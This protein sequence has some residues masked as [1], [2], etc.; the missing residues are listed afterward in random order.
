M[1]HAAIGDEVYNEFR[2]RF[3]GMF[4]DPRERGWSAYSASSPVTGSRHS[5]PL[6]IS[7][8]HPHPP[9]WSVMREGEPAATRGRWWR[10]LGVGIF[11]C[12]LPARVVDAGRT[13]ARSRW[14]RH[15]SRLPVGGGGTARWSRS[16]GAAPRNGGA[17]EGPPAAPPEADPSLRESCC[18][19]Q[20]EAA[21][22]NFSSLDSTS[23][24]SA[25]ALRFLSPSHCARA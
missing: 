25:S 16:P 4:R 7:P 17:P 10:G 14:G 15:D 9:G 6:T 24:S 21:L 20:C 18:F 1:S 5:V 2:G 8:V 19:F 3:F 12:H 13:A 22:R 11:F 23:A